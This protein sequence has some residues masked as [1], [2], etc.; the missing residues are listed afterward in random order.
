MQDKWVKQAFTIDSIVDSAVAEHSIN[1]QNIEAE[2]RK[3][4]L[5]LM[6]NEC[7]AIGA[8]SNQAK[9]IVEAIVQIVRIGLSEV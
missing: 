9:T 2:I 6:F 7:K 1:P 5:P 8:G 4:L 3:K